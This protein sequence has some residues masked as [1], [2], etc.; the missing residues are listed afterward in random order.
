MSMINMSDSMFVCIYYYVQVSSEDLQHK[1]TSLDLKLKEEKRAKEKAEGE[2][3]EM[4]KKFEELK[5][6]RVRV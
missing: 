6:S 1:I 5:K 3:T 4:L 2:S